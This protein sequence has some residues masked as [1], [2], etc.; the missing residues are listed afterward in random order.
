VQFAGQ[1]VRGTTVDLRA[2][3]DVY[4]DPDLMVHVLLLEAFAQLSGAHLRHRWGSQET[5]PRL[6]L[7]V[8]VDH[9]VFAPPAGPVRHASLYSELVHEQ[10]PFF[11]YR[12]Q[13]SYAEVVVC[14]AQIRLYTEVTS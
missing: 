3:H 13:A 11:T 4:G 7:L 2:P 10:Q 14:E 5:Q 1:A 12:A 6:G 8:S 9:S